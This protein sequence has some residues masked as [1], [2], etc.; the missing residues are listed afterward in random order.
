MSKAT[1]PLYRVH[2]RRRRE[3]RTDYAKRLGLLKSRIPRMV[4]RKTNRFIIVQCVSFDIKGDKT[5]C[6]VTSKKMK[7]N[8]NTPSAYAV[9]KELA[10][11]AIAKGVK[12]MVA[13]IGLHTATRGSVVF[14]ALKGAHDGGIEIT[15]AEEKAPA[16]DR[17]HGKHIAAKNKVYTWLN[18]RENG[19]HAR[20]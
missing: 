12:K 19:F 8:S 14:A 10:K 15:F 7:G 6:S 16:E 4:I 2:F 20:N 1:G 17:I 13:D 3:G 5:L 11:L 18:K 9:G